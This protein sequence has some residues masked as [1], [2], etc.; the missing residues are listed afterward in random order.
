MARG[1]RVCVCED[2]PLTRAYFVAALCQ[3]GMDALGVADGTALDQAM[4]IAEPDLVILDIG[5]PGEDGFAIA[6]RLRRERPRVGIVMLTALDEVDHRVRGLDSGADLY[7]AKPVD[8]RELVSALGSL[9]RRLDAAR[10][11]LACGGWRLDPGNAC[12]RTPSGAAV[13][14]TDNELRFLTPLLAAP[15]A[16]VEREDLA[17]ALDQKPDLYAM[18]RM[19]TLLS[20]L[21]AKVQRQCPEEPLP[22]RARHGRGYAFLQ[23]A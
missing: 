18:R 17:R 21:R 15:G 22:V 3:A 16:V 4:G 12:L 8:L 10:P 5:L 2:E 9:R 14:L 7:F 13:E 11:S 23:G 6:E 1:M 19:E 20:R